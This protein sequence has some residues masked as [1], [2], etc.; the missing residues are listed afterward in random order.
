MEEVK[1]RRHT[2]PDTPENREYVLADFDF[3]TQPA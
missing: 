1:S 2:M 3:W